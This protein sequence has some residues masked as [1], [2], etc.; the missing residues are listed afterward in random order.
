MRA[1]TP[2]TLHS[3]PVTLAILFISSTFE[4][5]R[6]DQMPHLHSLLKRSLAM[7]RVLSPS[8]KIFGATTAA[9]DFVSVTLLYFPA[10]FHLSSFRISPTDDPFDWT[11]SEWHTR[12]GMSDKNT[13]RPVILLFSHPD[14]PKLNDV[15]SGLDFAYPLARV[16]GATAAVCNALHHACIFDTDGCVRDGISG[17]AFSCAHV[18]LDF[19]IAQGARPVGPVLQVLQVRNGN[20]I[21]RVKEIGD[22]VGTEA[23]PM[24]MLDMWAHSDTVS[25]R[26]S[27]LAR[28][29]LLMGVEV[30]SIAEIAAAVAEKKTS[31]ESEGDTDFDMVVRK[32]VGFNEATNS[33]GLE[34]VVRLGCRVQF[35]IRDE[36][37]A[38]A[39]LITLFDRL[40]LEASTKVMDG[41]EMAGAIL[42]VDT[43][44]GENLYG[45]VTPDLDFEM[46]KERFPVP[47]AV[48][49]SDRQVGPL[50]TGGLQGRAGNTFALSASA[51]Y[52]CFYA[53]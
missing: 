28:K 22:G 11:P 8:T 50:P 18:A 16:A 23:A 1:A 10:P 49:T 31:V 12:V 30:P 21:T 40:H 4:T 45:D 2:F 24:L 53:R 46:F 25:E 39:E 13:T 3:T 20:E 26:D 6:P 29:Y 33:V 9:S 37:A 35:Q 42:F 15:L 5:S 44:R 14:F 47:L 51:L 32:V 17:L 43:E 52:L 34:G 27:R 38:R 19:G 48:L 36:E 7:R 41:M